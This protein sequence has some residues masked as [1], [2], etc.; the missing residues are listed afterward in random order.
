MET[1][2]S[3]EGHHL[4]LFPFEGHLVNEGLATL[5]AY[6]LTRGQPLTLSMAVNDYGLELLSDREIPLAGF[7]SRELFGTDRLL[8]DILASVNAAEMGRR[9]FREIARVAGLVFQGYPGRRKRGGQLQA[10]S[11]LLYNVFQR[12]E[13][14]NLLLEQATREVLGRQLAF[15]RLR[16]GLQRMAAARLRH[17]ETGRLTPLAFPIMVNRLRTRV[18]SEK[19]AERVARLQL[20]LEKQAD[21]QKTGG[22]RRSISP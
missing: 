8:E 9:Q 17:V 4:F 1:C 16:A 15:Q 21:K 10:S 5:L 20:R 22:A 11:S 12:Y 13:P 14:E 18:S 3:R 19:L 7:R 6:R 2:T